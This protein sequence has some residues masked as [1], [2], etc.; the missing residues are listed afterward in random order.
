MND[1]IEAFEEEVVYLL[2][3]FSKRLEE[4]GSN[5]LDG[6]SNEG[7]SKIQNFFQEVISNWIGEINDVIHGNPSC[8]QF[9]KTKMGLLYGIVSSYP[10]VVDVQS[11]SS[12]LMD[13]V[14]ALDRFLLTGFGKAFYHLS[15]C[16]N[17][18]LLQNFMTLSMTP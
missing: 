16:L 2:L 7:L 4:H 12:L 17:V 6:A 10:Y 15:R 14:D 11:N 5:L 3:N 18:E 13:L 1:L 8:I 9:Q